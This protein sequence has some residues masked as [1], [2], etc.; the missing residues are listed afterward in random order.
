MIIIFFG[1][2]GT[3]RFGRYGETRQESSV[4]HIM[5]IGNEILSSLT[6]SGIVLTGNWLTL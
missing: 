4:C 3:E 5:D 6:S 1:T 2:T